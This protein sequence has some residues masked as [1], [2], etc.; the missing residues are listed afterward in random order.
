MDAIQTVCIKRKCMKTKIKK[1]NK[2]NIKLKIKKKK[3]RVI[4]S[5]K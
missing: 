2:I 3:K 5:C 1:K 4:T